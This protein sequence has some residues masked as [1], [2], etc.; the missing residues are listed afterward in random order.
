MIA[1]MQTPE[2]QTR[3]DA[4]VV[5]LGKTGLACLRHLRQRGLTVA[6]ADTRLDPPLAGELR[7][8]LPEVELFT[9][10]LHAALLRRA[11]QL[12]VSPGVSIRETAIDEARQ[13]GV[14]VIGDIELFARTVD[15]PVI[16]ITGSNGKSTVT[17]L[18][19]FM[20]RESG[21]DVI[22]A[23]NIGTPA[24][25]LLA[26]TEHAFYA[27]ELSSFQLETTYTLRPAAAALLNVS[28]DHMDRYTT[29]A[30]YLEAKQRIHNGAR[31][32]VV[33]RDDPATR[34]RLPAAKIYTFGLDRPPGDRDFGILNLGGESWLTCGE[35]RLIDADA[36]QLAGRHNWANVL[37]ALALA[38][39]VG[40]DVQ[41]CAQAATR[42]QGLPHRM[43]CVA[44][45]NG[46]WWVNDSKAT[47]VG[48]TVSALSGVATPVILIAGGDGKGADFT[49]LQAAVEQH[50]R[51]LVLFGRDATM[52]DRAVG[53]AAAKYRV[54]DL[55]QGVQRASMLAES[56]DTVLFSPACA[57]FDMFTDYEQRG[58]AFRAA[59]R[60][61]S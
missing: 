20:G 46:V 18:V 47:N 42:F 61:L 10:E 48:A 9:G 30:E 13:S 15:Q 31:A 33:N 44:E 55:E 49:P 7:R 39:A 5:G 6:V 38:K 34:P 27:V 29:F 58:A 53:D 41:R 8:N 54:I 51:A 26:G 12:V 60:S 50:A 19:E 17:R 25:D 23:G 4:I 28:H 37:A 21:L 2:L 52:I 1:A 16:A 57:S 43:E 3:Y 11:R 56:G 59:V 22:A 36:L 35:R 45:I 32:A 24:L 40:W 14:E